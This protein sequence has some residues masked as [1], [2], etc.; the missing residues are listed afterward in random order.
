VEGADVGSL[1][2]VDGEGR[3][4]G[5]WALVRA[6]GPGLGDVAALAR[7][8]LEAR[9]HGCTLVL[10]EPCPRLLELLDLTGLAALAGSGGEPRRQAEGGEELG[11]EEV[12]QPRDPPA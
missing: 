3:V 7:L 1:A 4:V 6:G 8:H 9:R 5:R 10:L 2:L 12:V 11:V